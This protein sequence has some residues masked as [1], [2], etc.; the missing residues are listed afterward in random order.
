MKPE[1]STAVMIERIRELATDSPDSQDRVLFTQAANRIELMLAAESGMSRE[2]ACIRH[3]LDIPP[4]QSVQS[5]LVDAFVQ[6]NAK[7]QDLS[8]QLAELRGQEPVAW[9][10][11]AH[12]GD[13]LTRDGDYVANAE[14]M[15]SI[16]STPLYANPVPPAAS[17]PAPDELCRDKAFDLFNTFPDGDVVDCVQY[18]WNACRAAM[19][20]QNN[21]SPLWNGID[22]AEGCAPAIPDGWV[23]VPLAPTPEMTDAAIGCGVTRG[24]G[25]SLDVNYRDIYTAMVSAAPQAERK[26]GDA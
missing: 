9:I 12:G 16:H 23:L 14:G 15:H 8:G 1:I 5:G 25:G 18:A 20:Q 4:D 22:W 2:M 6:L 13:Q 10:V 26:D 11:H 21:N 17:Q 7:I 3:A 24:M 19:L